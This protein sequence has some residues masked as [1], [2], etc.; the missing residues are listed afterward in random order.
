MTLSWMFWGVHSQW[1]QYHGI[2]QVEHI[3]KYRDTH[4]VFRL[5]YDPQN[6][7]VIRPL[8]HILGDQGV[9]L[10]ESPQQ[11][12]HIR[13]SGGMSNPIN[14]R[15]MDWGGQH[16]PYRFKKWVFAGNVLTHPDF[17]RYMWLKNTGWSSSWG[18]CFYM[19]RKMSGKGMYSNGGMLG[20][21]SNL[22]SPFTIRVSV[23]T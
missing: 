17:S 20:L 16:I 18:K 21:H 7:W 9:T 22:T 11:G 14:W 3:T 4:H 2:L 12:D 10:L 8:D 15:S 13:F 6:V 23:S 19:Q 5:P 1:W